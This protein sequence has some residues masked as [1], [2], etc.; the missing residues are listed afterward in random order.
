MSTIEKD[1]SKLNV[2][3]VESDYDVDPLFKIMTMKFNEPG[4]RNLL[5]NILPVT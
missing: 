3:K 1:I 4:A 5:L 2:D